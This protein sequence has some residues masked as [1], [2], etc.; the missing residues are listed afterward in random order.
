MIR[1]WNAISHSRTKGWREMVIINEWWNQNACCSK[2]ILRLKRPNPLDQIMIQWYKWSIRT[3]GFVSVGW[4]NDDER[5]ISTF[6]R[7]TIRLVWLTYSI[8][9]FNSICLKWIDSSAPE[10]RMWVFF[11]AHSI[12]ERS[13]SNPWNWQLWRWFHLSVVADILHEA[14]SGICSYLHLNRVIPS[15]IPYNP[16][17]VAFVEESESH[18]S[19]SCR[20][21]EESFL[22]HKMDRL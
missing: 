10:S 7:S 18:S 16:K 22:N 5:E 15:T 12:T 13:I 4:L 11:L 19:Q 1:N 3:L 21:L 9:F 20:T 17:W 8:V 6:D 2:P 14:N